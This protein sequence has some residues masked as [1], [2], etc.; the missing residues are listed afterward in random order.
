L[1]KS[2]SKL[3]NLLDP[4]MSTLL[5]PVSFSP[6]DSG[7]YM[8]H[9]VLNHTKGVFRTGSYGENLGKQRYFGSEEARKRLWEH[10]VEATSSSL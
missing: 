10:T 5:R 6:E 1:K 3:L 8:W 2:D 4:I 7:E 9:A